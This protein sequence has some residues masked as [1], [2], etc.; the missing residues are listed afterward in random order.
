MPTVVIPETSTAANTKSSEQLQGSQL[1]YL[2]KDGVINFFAKASA[3]GLKL[4]IMV[5]GE[6]VYDDQDVPIIKAAGAALSRKDDL[7]LSVAGRAGEQV[8]VFARNST[9]GAITWA[10]W[11]EML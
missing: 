7:L 8:R 2:P 11:A 6:T 3:I 5:G 4:T 1:A 9:A 10:V